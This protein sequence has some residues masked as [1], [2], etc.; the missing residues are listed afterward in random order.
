MRRREKNKELHKRLILWGEWAEKTIGLLGHRSRNSISIMIEY[1]EMCRS[2]NKPVSMSPSYFPD[3]ECSE[4]EAIV[5][6]LPQNLR[7]ALQAAY[8]LRLKKGELPKYNFKVRT[9][10]RWVDKASKRVAGILGITYED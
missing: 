5:D 9:Y 10:Y 4:I 2:G 8:V 3:R 7:K 1:Q 6:E